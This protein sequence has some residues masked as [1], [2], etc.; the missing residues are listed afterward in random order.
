L[1]KKTEFSK[2]ET[3]AIKF[4][5]AFALLFASSTTALT[6]TGAGSG[7]CYAVS[8]GHLVANIVPGWPIPVQCLLS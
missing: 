1:T 3:M 7:G 8:D 2:S 5:T 6:C 4:I